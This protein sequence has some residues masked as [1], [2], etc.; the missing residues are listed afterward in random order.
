MEN[1]AKVFISTQCLAIFSGREVKLFYIIGLI[2]TSKLWKFALKIKFQFTI[3]IY[4]VSISVLHTWQFCVFILTLK[5]WIFWMLFTCFF[6]FLFLKNFYFNFAR[7][8]HMSFKVIYWPGWL[9]AFREKKEE[10]REHLRVLTEF[11]WF[12]PK[13]W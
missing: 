1:C 11:E 3:H 10:K 12:L 9:D 4:K 13:F 7:A 5:F 2:Q 6:L 8:R